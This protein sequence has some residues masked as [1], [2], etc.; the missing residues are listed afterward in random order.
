MSPAESQSISGG[1]CS[2]ISAAL[3]FWFTFII[4]PN[5]IVVIY[6]KQL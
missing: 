4:P 1:L 3:P 6:L 2:R 5:Q